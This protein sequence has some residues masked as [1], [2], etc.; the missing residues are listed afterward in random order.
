MNLNI[1]SNSIISLL[2]IQSLP[3]EQKVSIIEK[4]TALVEKRLLVRIF[5][6][7]DALRQNEFSDL[8]EKSDQA[9]LQEFLDRQVPNMNEL[10]EQE[11]T[12]V[13]GEL[14]DWVENLA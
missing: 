9:A 3:D 4:V 13:K 6:S 10:A 11:I 7:L 5:D 2:G 14:V 8:L 1:D 12:Q